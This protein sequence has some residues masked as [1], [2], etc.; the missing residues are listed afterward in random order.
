MSKNKYLYKGLLAFLCLVTLGLCGYYFYKTFFDKSKNIPISNTVILNAM[1]IKT[2]NVLVKKS[3]V[4]H[5]EAINQIQVIPYING[6]LNKII[7]KPGQMVNKNDLLLTIDD[8]EYKAKLEAADAAVLQAT[9]AFD[10][11]K[12]YY[13]RVQKSGKRAFSEIDIDNAK[14]NFLQA[15]ATL[16]NAVA[17]RKLAKVNFK[18]TQ[19]KAS[20]T[21]LVGNFTLSTGDYVSPSGNSLF[22]IIQ[23]N[24]IRVVFSLT[25]TEYLN[26]KEDGELFK[27]SVIKLIL[28]NGKTFANDGDFKYTDNHLNK[29]TNS[30][31]VY[32]YFQ[33]KNNELLPNSYV[34]VD[35]Y[36][37]FKNAV[38]LDKNL[39]KMKEDGYFLTIGRNEHIKDIKVQ[40]LSEKNNQYVLKNIFDK[41]DVLVLD[42]TNNLKPNVK[43]H[44]NLVN[45]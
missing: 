19:I 15:E 41:E 40:I 9:A 45:V 21:G 38:I 44:F 12:E 7:V 35:V 29:N 34:T 17:A 28:A 43:I 20:I 2:E 4:G 27:D 31:A 10:Y 25:D 5:V 18:Y 23:T 36:K 24:P 8:G 37:T 26:L 6:Y 32:A 42:D 33:N 22:S 14:N 1:P 16:K 3:Y 13:D 39:V 30:L 11:S